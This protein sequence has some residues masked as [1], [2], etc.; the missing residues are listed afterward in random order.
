[1]TIY[2]DADWLARAI[3]ERGWIRTGY[4]GHHL[5][6]LCLRINGL[7]EDEAGRAAALMGACPFRCGAGWSIQLLGKR[8]AL[9]LLSAVAPW[10]RAGALRKDVAAVLASR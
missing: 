5:H 3:E 6:R 2:Q 8:R 1:M 7:S 10:F 9:A 4:D